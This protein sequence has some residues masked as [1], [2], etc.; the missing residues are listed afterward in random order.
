MYTAHFHFQNTDGSYIQ[1][2]P[3][4][5]HLELQVGPIDVHYPRFTLVTQ[6]C[7]DK[8]YAGATL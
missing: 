1:S 4:C 6:D 8:E 5:S 2:D 7:F 3:T